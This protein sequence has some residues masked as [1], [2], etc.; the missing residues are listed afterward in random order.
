MRRRGSLITALVVV[1]SLM[2]GGIAWALTAPARVVYFEIE[3]FS[4]DQDQKSALDA[5]VPLLEDAEQ[6]RI[7]GYVQ[8]SREGDE[9]K[10]AARLSEKRAQSVENYLRSQVKERSKNKAEISWV[11][12]GRGQPPWDVG[13]PWARRVEIFIE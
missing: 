8:R 5:V 10:G 4:L 6:V 9:N 7:D 12:V 1:V 2:G 13:L 11:S 3:D